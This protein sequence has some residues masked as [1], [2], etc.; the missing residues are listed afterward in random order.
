MSKINDNVTA[1]DFRFFILFWFYDLCASHAVFVKF[2]VSLGK[3]QPKSVPVE[4]QEDHYSILFGY[5]GGSFFTGNF[6]P[7]HLAPS[8][9]VATR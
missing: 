1:A 6:V 2:L 5:D 3:L 8:M 7:P 9:G 4:Y